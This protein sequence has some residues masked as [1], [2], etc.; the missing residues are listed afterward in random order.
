M[1]SAIVGGI[2]L[3][4]S[5]NY[6]HF[7]F[8][9]S[10]L[11]NKAYNYK[12]HSIH[13]WKKKKGKDNLVAFWLVVSG[14]GEHI[15]YLTMW[16]FIKAALKEKGKYLKPS[17]YGAFLTKPWWE[18]CYVSVFGNFNKPWCRTFIK[19]HFPIPILILATHTY[20]LLLL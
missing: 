3:L 20:T 11:T 9:I 16:Q 6:S 14:T 1:L 4:G 13:I 19:A 15:S 8:E 12:Y 17:L 18:H 10:L 2:S 7:L 5:I